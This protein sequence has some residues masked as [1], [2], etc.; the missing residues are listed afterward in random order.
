[1]AA[2]G[3]G[4]PG[5]PARGGNKQ[6]QKTIN[7]VKMTLICGFITILVLRGTVGINLMAFSGDGGGD[8]AADAKVAEDIER[9]LREIRSDSDPDDEDQ[10]VVDASLSGNST[11]MPV[12]EEKNYTLGPSITRWNA[13]R[14]QWLSQNP[15]FPSRDARGSPRI[16]LVTGSSPGPCDNPAGDHYL[17]KSTKNK[18]DYCRLHGIEI[19]HNMVH[20]DRELSGYWSKLPL[21]RRLMLSHPE[22]EWV[23]WMDSDALFT[24]MGF[25]IPLSRYEGSNLVI[26]GYPELLNNQRSWVALNTGSFLLRNCQWSMELLDAWA[27]MGPKG[28]VREAAGKVLTASLTGRPAFEADD[29]SALIH[30]LLTEKDRWMEKVY[31][32][33]QYYLHGFWAGLVD[34]YEEMMEKHHPGLGDERWPFITHFVGCKPCGSYGDYP[35]EQCLTGMERAFNF[36]DNQVL[37]L[38]GFRHRS[39][40]NPKVKPVANR[41]ASPLVNKEASL[42]MDA[43]IET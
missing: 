9:I 6:M 25:E 12:V 16:L 36:A 27:P 2:G 23:W 32:E 3:L 13:K 19:V 11:T 42:K 35:V 33:N 20:L 4:R 14:R 8:A 31:V 26:H 40:T 28:R 29:Q 21:L 41:T 1:M 22:V 43:K 15:G 38:Y 18:I 5:R 24:D 37:R 10:L 39:L 34:K 17:L 30:L 7:N